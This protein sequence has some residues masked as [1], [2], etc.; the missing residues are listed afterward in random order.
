MVGR[1]VEARGLIGGSFAADGMGP[2][3]MTTEAG[4]CCQAGEALQ[5]VGRNIGCH[6]VHFSFVIFLNKIDFYFN[7]IIY[8]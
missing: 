1:K 6:P 4:G 8:F 2:V 3:G 7:S 5:V